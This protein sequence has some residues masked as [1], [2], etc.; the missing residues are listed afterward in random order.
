MDAQL[1]APKP[2]TEA[3]RSEVRNLLKAIK[4]S[5]CQ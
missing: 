1:K 2:L 5:I 3:Q 4:C